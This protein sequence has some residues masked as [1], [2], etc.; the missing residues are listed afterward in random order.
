MERRDLCISR[1]PLHNSVLVNRI[2]RLT[3]GAVPKRL[4][5]LGREQIIFSQEFIMSA[6]N[7]DKSRF[8]RE[9]KQKIARRKRTHELLERVPKAR[10]SADPAGSAQARSVSA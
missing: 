3:T 5:K 6:R 2:A 9:R 1:F 8:N 10:K 7:G 4:A